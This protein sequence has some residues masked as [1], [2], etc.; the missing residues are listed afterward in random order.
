MLSMSIESTVTDSPTDI[1]ALVTEDD[2]GIR[3]F[4]S[5][6]LEVRGFAVLSAAN[7]T[8]SVALSESY[9][10]PIAMLITDID[11][12]GGQNGIE[13]ADLIVALRPNITVLVISGFRDREAMATAKGYSFLA[14][15]FTDAELGKGVL[16][17]LLAKITRADAKRHE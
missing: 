17:A 2:V 11:L 15:P 6:A 13:L 5:T 12:G 7:A 8:E 16:E 14:K 9:A 1:A 10:G 3:A 4:I